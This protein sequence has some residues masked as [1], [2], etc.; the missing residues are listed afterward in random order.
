MKE[1]F[2]GFVAIVLASC[3]SP[4]GSDIGQTKPIVTWNGKGPITMPL[5]SVTLDGGL[6]FFVVEL[7]VD[8]QR[9]LFMVDTGSNVTWF[10]DEVARSMK[11]GA[12]AERTE[13]NGVG[14]AERAKLVVIES[15]DL[16]FA[17]LHHVPIASGPVLGSMN[18]ALVKKGEHPFSGV[19]G[20]NVLVPL[21]ASL[22]LSRSTITFR[23]SGS[24]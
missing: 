3:T 2:L 16:G 22:D 7:S 17:R 21:G 11:V 9:G 10:T 13:V 5:D 23:D 8:G 12:P 4:S 19:L 15:I 18:R 6:V 14:G 24:H 1:S 20:L